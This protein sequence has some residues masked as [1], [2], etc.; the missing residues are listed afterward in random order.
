MQV[1]VRALNVLS[2]VADSSPSCSLTDVSRRV[3]L[4]LST[5]HRLLR[6][7]V[8]EGYLRYDTSTQRYYPGTRL[9][10][11]AHSSGRHGTALDSVVSELRT[12]SQKV[13]ETSFVT[14]LIGNRA[15][16][17]AL[18]ESHRPLR[19]TVAVGQ[20]MPLHA[21]ASARTLLAYQPTQLLQS[22]FKGYSFKRF[23]SE[24]PGGIEEVQQ[25]L[26]AI[27]RRGY[28]VC[29]NEFDSNVWA[30][31][32]PIAAID[33]NVI[34][35]LTVAAPADRCSTEESRDQIVEAVLSA[36]QSI[37]IGAYAAG[38]SAKEATKALGHLTVDTGLGTFDVSDMRRTAT[39]SGRETASS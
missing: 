1:V 7:L 4:P 26:S 16:C 5:T 25:H 15:V 28:D 35:A 6:V 10:L 31:A 24:T 14:E 18:V 8:Q 27:R 9:A 32:A 34:A 12:L 33:G 17:V 11:I 30:V 38:G 36:A 3:G 29:S 39:V 2:V 13:G 23:T 20:D 37:G 21:A 19:I 22:F